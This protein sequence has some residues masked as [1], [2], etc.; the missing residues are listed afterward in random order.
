MRLFRFQ[1]VNSIG[2][3]GELSVRDHAG[4]GSGFKRAIGRAQFCAGDRLVGV[5]ELEF[6]DLVRCVANVARAQTGAERDAA[7]S[8][9]TRLVEKLGLS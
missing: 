4:S 7:R 5:D 6:S 2:D 9:A 3:P 1:V 8:D